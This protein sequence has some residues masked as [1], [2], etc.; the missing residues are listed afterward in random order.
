MTFFD[1]KSPIIQRLL[2]FLMRSCQIL[3]LKRIQREVIFKKYHIQYITRICHLHFVAK[4]HWGERG[5]KGKLIRSWHDVWASFVKTVLALDP[6]DPIPALSFPNSTARTSYLISALMFP[7]H[8]SHLGPPFLYQGSI[9]E[10]KTECGLLCTWYSSSD[11][12]FGTAREKILT[13]QVSQKPM[14][15]VMFMF[16]C[17]QFHRKKT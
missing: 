15:F 5:K 8:S 4:E 10:P 17:S 14:L 6:G 9:I 3:F 1:I 11:R 12:S 2:S 13:T 7:L 16:H